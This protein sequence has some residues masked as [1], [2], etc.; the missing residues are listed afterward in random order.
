MSD[1]EQRNEYQL[2]NHH[3][4]FHIKM[5]F[6]ECCGRICF[7]I[8]CNSD[9]FSLNQSEIS[10]NNLLPNHS[11]TYRSLFP[12]ECNNYRKISLLHST[13]QIFFS[14]VTD[15]PPIVHNS[16]HNIYIRIILTKNLSITCSS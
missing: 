1:F 8:S 14:I 2:V 15:R 4:F 3:S 16:K 7:I 10:F 5:N 9:V 12:D 6:L 11:G 13:C